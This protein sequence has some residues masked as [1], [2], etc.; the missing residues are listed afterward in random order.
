MKKKN[1]MTVQRKTLDIVIFVDISLFF[2]SLV[3][4]T[5]TGLI[6]EFCLSCSYHDDALDKPLI[7]SHRH[8]ISCKS[9]IACSS[10]QILHDSNA[11]R[12]SLT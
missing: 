3:V 2:L 11:H 5:F 1:Y 10:L 8:T 12:T 4:L 6:C 7:V 9:N